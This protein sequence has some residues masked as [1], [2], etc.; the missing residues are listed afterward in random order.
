MNRRDFPSRDVGQNAHFQQQMLLKAASYSPGP[1]TGGFPAATCRHGWLSADTASRVRMGVART[2]LSSLARVPPR[3]RRLSRAHS[4][5]PAL[6][7]ASVMTAAGRLPGPL[8][9]PGPRVTL[10]QGQIPPNR[11][12]PFKVKSKA[13]AGPTSLA[14]PL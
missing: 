13:A 4:A 11:L 7:A 9:H 2:P 3:A 6:P 12:D 5:L 14:N 1:H 8:L 10:V